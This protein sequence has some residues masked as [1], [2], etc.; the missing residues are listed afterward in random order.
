MLGAVRHKGFVP[1]DDDIDVVM[2][3]EDYDKFGEIAL[4]ELPESYFLLTKDTA[5]GS[6][7]WSMK[8]IDTNTT[9]LLNRSINPIKHHQG[10]ALDIVPLDGVPSGHSDRVK[11]F[12]KREIV[13]ALTNS[14]ISDWKELAIKGKMVKLISKIHFMGRD[15]SYCIGKLEK[16]WAE[17]QWDES[18]FVAE[19]AH[20]KVFEKNDFSDTV[21]MEFEGYQVPLPVG[22]EHIL[23]Q[24]YGDYMAMPPVQQRMIPEDEAAGWIVEPDVPYKDYY[25]IIQKSKKSSEYA[26]KK[27]YHAYCD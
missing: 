15:Y 27:R 9:C 23:Q 8:L 25:E 18:E 24:L 10:L 13:L 12:W 2:P 17:Y 4:N 6:F 21:Y 14:Y 19:S 20:G 1:W 16:V 22:Y 3:R 11:Q 7:Y 26:R 5:Q